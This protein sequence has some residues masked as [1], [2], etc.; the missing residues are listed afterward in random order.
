C[1]KKD[2]VGQ[3]LLEL[4]GDVL[5]VEYIDTVTVISFSSIVDS[6]PT[7]EI[8]GNML[9]SYFDP[10]FGVT[11]T[12]FY[13]QIRMVSNDLDFGENAVYDSV[14][15][16]LDYNYIYGEDSL[17]EQTIKVY[18]LDQDIYPDSTYYSNDK[19]QVHSSEIGN[20]KVVFNNRD[21]IDEGKYKL[22]AHLR[23]RLDDVFGLKIF[24]KSGEP[25]LSNNEEF[26]KFIKG[27]YVTAD[28]I[29]SPGG[30]IAGINL[31]SSYSRLAIFYHDDT[32]TLTSNFVINENTARVQ[33]F[34]HYDYQD[35]SASF[36][37]QVINK[38][39]T[40]GAQNFYLQPMAGV[41]A[42]IRFPFL[43]ELVKNGPIALNKAELVLQPDPIFMD[44]EGP[45]AEIV[46]VKKTADGRYL[47]PKDEDEGEL[48]FGGRYDKEKKQY[49]FTI[50]RHLQSI[51]T[52]DEEDYGMVLLIKGSGVTPNRVIFIGSKASNRVRLRLFYTEV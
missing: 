52:G 35:A 47:F 44:F 33:V 36:I 26:V 21:S 29:N 27:L 30:D 50:T 23:L 20:V 2:N 25:E 22:H 15:L 3:E 45:P 51:L 46:L 48:F 5:G 6:F 41:K 24:D 39:S 4:P 9:G 28:R 43:K 19:F 14:V 11:T 17:F 38:D 34:D 49:Y 10:D 8:G 31:L 7:D 42:A 37:S 16:T 13:T 18:E 12:G 32:D 1:T 40:L